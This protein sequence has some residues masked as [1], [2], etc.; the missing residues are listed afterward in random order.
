MNIPDPVQPAS[1]LFHAVNKMYSRDGFIFRFHPS[2]GQQA[3]EVVAG[4]LV[5]LT[6]LWDGMI[7]TTKF[8]KFFTDGAI[9]RA[10]EAWWDTE[11]LCV[12]TKA[13][14]EMT[15]ILTYDTDLIFPETKV[16][17]E[18]SGS[19]SLAPMIAKIQD[20]LLSTGSISTFRSLVTSASTNTHAMRCSTTRSKA[21]KSK[22]TKAT[23]SD[24]VT[25]SVNLSESDLHILLTRLTQA[26]NVQIIAPLTTNKEPTGGQNTGSKNDSKANQ[27][28]TL[29]SNPE[30]K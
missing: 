20:D 25:S 24:S 29:Q 23:D 28:A 13:D 7:N 4:L 11:T 30:N 27:E 9:E 10:R 16:E 1:K 6:G 17:L 14:Q 26:L 22:T 2:R 21:T 15:N 19:T 12:A 18:M 8:H 3:R 5:F